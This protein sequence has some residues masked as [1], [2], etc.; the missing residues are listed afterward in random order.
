MPK[1]SKKMDESKVLD[2]LVEASVSNPLESQRGLERQIGV[3][4][5]HIGRILRKP[6]TRERVQEEL[7][8]GGAMVHTNR[9]IGAILGALSSLVDDMLDSGVTEPDQVTELTQL[10]GAFVG[11]AERLARA[12]IDLTRIADP[13]DTSALNLLLRETYVRALQHAQAWGPKRT[14]RAMRLL[15]PRRGGKK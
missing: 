14:E 8:Q 10:L 2:V 3:S 12:G 5:A 15:T 1:R 9:S 6:I 13:N 4:K 7:S 11:T